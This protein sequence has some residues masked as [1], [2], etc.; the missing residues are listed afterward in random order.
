[1]THDLV[2]RNGLVIDGT[3]APARQGDVAVAGD[4]IVAIGDVP[5]RGREEIDA[6]GHIVAPGFIDGHTHLDA[7]VFWDPMG[8]CA[9]WH[10]VTSV[11]MGNCGFTLAPCAESDQDLVLRNL[12][13]AE[14]I[15][16]EA[17]LAGIE[18][19]WESYADYLD[20]V[21]RAPKGIN[22]AGYIGHS[23]VR[24]Y[25]MGERAFE[26]PA[27][28]DDLT[29]M[30]HEVQSALES[31]AIG[32]STSLSSAHMTSDDRPVA[33]RISEWDE[34]VALMGVLRD[35]GTGIFELSN[36]F[37]DDDD[38][39]RAYLARLRDLAL[40]SGRP[41]TYACVS[42]P[43]IPTR[44]QE[45][46]DIADSCARMGGRMIP[47]VHS[48]QLQS[49]IGFRGNLPFDCLPE[50]R[51]L[52]GRTLRE[53]R[54]ALEDAATRARLVDEALHGHYRDA[55]GTEARPPRY[56]VVGVIDDPIGPWPTVAEV[57]EARGV[58]P[59]DVMIDLS[60]ANDFRQLFAQ[61]FSNIDLDLV[62]EML[63]HERSVI[64]LSDTGAHVSQIIDSSIPTFL[65]EYWVREREVFTWE[66]AIRMLTSRPATVF[67]F[68]DRGVLREGF[69]ADLVVFDPL[70]IGPAMPEVGCDLPAGAK[71]LKQGAHG[72]H[73][74]VVNGQPVLR[75]GEHTG[76]LPGRVLRANRA[77][78]ATP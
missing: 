62:L 22:Y 71:R 78:A 31:G 75:N 53:Q 45:L 16:R 28:E 36:A 48:R 35:R 17:M 26:E 46:L 65:L 20:A 23:A 57:A 25:V 14:D 64:A 63:R 58:S 50:W 1:V 33:S 55:I 66:A 9:S 51:E 7:Q 60:L 59:V 39:R 69:R 44:H 76:A 67:G 15:A 73:A 52:R 40:W 37:L 24:T 13:R 38:E 77:E 4:R 54:A 68:H 27:T 2:V 29:A 3:G 34:L 6:E 43:A 74:V 47:Q 12:E 41:I 8:T 49:V 19:Q 11:A 5:E 70:R 21:E 18:W 10:G 30:R 42:V 56:D 61:P 32:F 72:L